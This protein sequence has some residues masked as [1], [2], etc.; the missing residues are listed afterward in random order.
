MASLLSSPTIAA[1][2]PLEPRARGA[3]AT[4]CELVKARLC[5]LVLLTT[6][7]GFLLASRGAIHLGALLWTMIGAALAA[8]GANAVNQCIEAPRDARMLRTRGRPLP[9]G[10]LSPAAGWRVGVALALAGPLVL[11]L[12][13][14]PVTAGLAAVCALVYVFAYTPLKTRTPMNTLV[15]AVCGAIPPMIG[16]AGATGGLDAGAW[17]LG[18]LLFVWQIPHFLALA[19]LYRDDYRAGGFRMLPIVDAGGQLT[20][21]ACLLYS[22]ALAPVSLMLS[23][24]GVTNLVFACGALVAAIAMVAASLALYRDRSRVAARRL[25]LASVIYLPILL[26]LMVADRGGGASPAAAAPAWT[27]ADR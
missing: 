1:D 25:F 21:E 5:A 27:D 15:G 20:C 14:N 23:I 7:V 16:W 6:L 8:F 13:V 9:S 18:A 26:A 22:L 19:W 3:V 24:A 12:A 2:I 4:L 10:R 11:A 17:L